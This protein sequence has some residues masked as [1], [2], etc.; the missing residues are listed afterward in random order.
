LEAARHAVEAGAEVEDFMRMRGD[1]LGRGLRNIYYRAYRTMDGFIAVACLNNALRRKLRDLLGVD[2]PKV[3]GETYV[4][5]SKEEAERLRL[6]AEPI[7]RARTTD[8]WYALLDEVGIP[9]GPLNAPEQIPDDPQVQANG[10]ILRL[11]HPV[12][13]ELRMAGNPLRFSETPVVNEPSAP[14]ILGSATRS[15]L[16]EQGYDE[17]Q[18]R[19]LTEQGVVGQS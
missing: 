6:A 2:D 18:I 4:G 3:D 8:E 7:M 1:F 16:L 5:T 17:E 14:P 13:G 11:Q 19:L 9:C 15:V 10:S 12:L